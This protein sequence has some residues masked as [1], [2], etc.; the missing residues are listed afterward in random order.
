VSVRGRV[1]PL[2]EKSEPVK[3]ACEI[4]TDDPPV[5]VRVSDRFVLVPT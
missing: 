5:L 4:V 1:N 3:L 2:I